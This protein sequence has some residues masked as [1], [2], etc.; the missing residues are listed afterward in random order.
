VNVS[1]CITAASDTDGAEV[2][3]VGC[4]DSDLHTTFP[5]GNYT[6]SVPVAPFT[7]QIKTFNNKCLDVPNGSTANGVKLQLWTCTPGNTNQIFNH[8]GTTQIE[9]SGKGKCLDATNGVW[10]NGNP[11][12]FPVVRAC[13]VVDWF[14][15]PDVGLCCSRQQPQPGLVPAVMCSCVPMTTDLRG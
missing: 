2:A 6:W 1:H 14:L 8:R 7:G 12:R 13:A 5:K 15:D 3:I 4:N 9:W 11:V 10:T